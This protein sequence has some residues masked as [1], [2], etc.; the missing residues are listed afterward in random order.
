MKGVQGKAIISLNDH[1]QIRECFAKFHIET[2]DIKC[3]V[4][5]KG[6]C[7]REV[8]I[9]SWDI[10][11]QPADFFDREIKLKNPCYLGVFLINQIHY[12]DLFFDFIRIKTGFIPLDC[13]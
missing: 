12:I 11:A 6:I 10:K 1:P 4:G 2:A 9:F 7:A 5:G 3:A 13:A 8:L